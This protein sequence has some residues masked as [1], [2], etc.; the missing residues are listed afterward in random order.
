V[1]TIDIKDITKNN[2]LRDRILTT[3][4]V[5][6]M[7]WHPEIINSSFSLFMCVDYEDGESYLRAD[8]SIKCGD[9]RNKLLRNS[10]GLSF[11]IIWGLIFPAVIYKQI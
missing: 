1:N 4:F 7:M 9:Q 2:E 8:T 11:I 3:F 5:I 6:I 10:I